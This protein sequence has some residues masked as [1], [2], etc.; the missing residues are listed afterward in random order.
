M[1]LA[2]LVALVKE[3]GIIPPPP[4]GAVSLYLSSIL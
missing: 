3:D 1:V 4:L 2:A